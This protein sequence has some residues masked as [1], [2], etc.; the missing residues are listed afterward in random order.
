VLEKNIGKDGS[1]VLAAFGKIE[2]VL[3]VIRN[4][5]FRATKSLVAALG[6]VRPSA[7]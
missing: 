1:A 2:A 3:A 6:E 7:R 4:G 5:S